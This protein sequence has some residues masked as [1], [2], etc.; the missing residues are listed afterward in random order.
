MKKSST[1]FVA[2]N[3][4]KHSIDIAVAEAPRDAEVRHLGTVRGGCRCG[5]KSMR[6]L[7]SAGHKL[8]IVYEAGPC[9]FVL[10]RHFSGLGTVA[11]QRR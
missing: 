1:L 3:V 7:V 9:G 2:L 4:H 11:S 8:H 10:Q 5:A 6:K